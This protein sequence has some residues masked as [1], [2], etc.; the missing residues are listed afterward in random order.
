MVE[1]YYLSNIS[2]KIGRDQMGGT[3]SMKMK[4]IAWYSKSQSSEKSVGS[5]V[6]C[7]IKVHLKGMMC[8]AAESFKFAQDRYELGAIL[9]KVVTFKVSSSEIQWSLY[10]PPCLKF[11]NFTF[12]PRSVFMCFVWI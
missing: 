4:R 11:T 12:Y 1:I 2:V 10:V 5:G 7:N 3:H 8:C 9:N 6:K